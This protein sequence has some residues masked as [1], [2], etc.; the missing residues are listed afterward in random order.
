MSILNFRNIRCDGPDCKKEVTFDPKFEKEIFL[1]PEN[2]WLRSGR[3]IQT[4]DQRILMYCSDVCEINGIRSGVHNLPEPK[5]V[6][7]AGT[8]AAVVAAAQAAAAAKA[9]DETLKAGTGGPV[10]VQG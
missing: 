9:S 3:V 4:G 6:I 2:A 1:A 10:I 8:P 5:K 7:E